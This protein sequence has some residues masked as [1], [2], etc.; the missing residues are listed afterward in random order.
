L[1]VAAL[2]FVL[3]R[4]ES[5]WSLYA[6]YAGMGVAMACTL[7]EP[8]F[9]VLTHAFRSNPRRAI[10]LV[11][12][13]GGLAGT[14]FWPLTQALIGWLGWRDTLLVLAALNLLVCAPLHARA[15][16]DLGA[17]DPPGP[18]AAPRADREAAHGGVSAGPPEAAHALADAGAASTDEQ[19]LRAIRAD[20]MFRALRLTFIG[21]ALLFSSLLVHLMSA[22][23]HKGLD[24]SQAALIGAMIGPMQIAG[25][26]L[27]LTWG[28]RLPILRVGQV[29]ICLLPGALLLL[30]AI[31]AGAPFW[32][33]ALFA[34]PFGLGNGLLTIVRGSAVTELWGRRYYGRISGTIAMPVLAA[35]ALG[36]LAAAWLLRLSGSYDGVLVALLA[37]GLT[38]AAVFIAAVRARSRSTRAG[39]R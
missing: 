38:A 14:L 12:L 29:A 34:L 28:R 26:L 17:D 9:A 39:E 20:P 5:A 33:I 18:A 35:N 37:V 10:T 36:P 15:L 16:P 19:D 11:T 21:H 7:Y 4:V 8:A 6:V 30:W 32:T 1:A 22:L 25:R 23:Q 2:L 27:E 24:A 31:P 13:F 3:S